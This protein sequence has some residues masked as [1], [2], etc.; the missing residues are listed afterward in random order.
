M[1][2]HG[3]SVRQSRIVRRKFLLN[4]LFY[5]HFSYSL[6]LFSEDYT[7]EL[8]NHVVKVDLITY[9]LQ[10]K[11]K[12]LEPYPTSHIYCTE[13]IFFNKFPHI[14]IKYVAPIFGRISLPSP[15]YLFWGFA[16]QSCFAFCLYITLFFHKRNLTTSYIV[17]EIVSIRC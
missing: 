12:M 10:F 14:L 16:V 11:K 3:N 6:T 13:I 1:L 7:F 17:I 2:F 9:I 15:D 4:K 8:Q 5:G